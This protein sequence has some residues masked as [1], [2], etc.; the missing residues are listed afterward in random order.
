MRAS[1]DS[2]DTLTA[3]RVQACVTGAGGFLGSEIV[4]QLLQ[5]GHSVCAAVRSEVPPCHLTKWQAHFGEKRL[6]ICIGLD[7]T[8]SGAC[9]DQAMEGCDSL[10]HTAALFPSVIATPET[11]DQVVSS[12]VLG[13]RNVLAAAARQKVESIVVTSS[14]AAVRGPA[15]QPR[16][17][18]TYFDHLDWNHSSR[19]MGRQQ[20]APLD[21]SLLSCDILCVSICDDEV[22]GKQE[23]GCR[24]TNG[25]KRAQSS[26]HLK[27][28]IS[29][30]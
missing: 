25:P 17:G 14:V 6:K 19:L 21:Q 26:W 28:A 22:A 2:P 12:C 1:V 27:W 13:T 29:W 15:D 5:N 3:L 9:L 30:V 4:L 16:H 20:C 23:A 8:H 11:G 18:R 10:F 7:I 24:F